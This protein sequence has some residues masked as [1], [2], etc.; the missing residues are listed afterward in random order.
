MRVSVRYNC[1]YL[2][3]H[4]CLFL[5][6]FR[7]APFLLSLLPLFSPLPL[8]SPPLS[9]SLLLIS[10]SLLLPFSYLLPS[11]SPPPFFSPSPSLYS[12]SQLSLLLSLS[13]PSSLFSTFFSLS[14]LYN[15]YILLNNTDATQRSWSSAPM[16]SLGIFATRRPYTWSARSAFVLPNSTS[17]RQCIVFQPTAGDLYRLL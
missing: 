1:Y 4:S 15:L 17:F 13:T 14:R 3:R 9:S 12:L 16:P 7:C 5:W 8:V 2:F 6:Y 11:F 10:S